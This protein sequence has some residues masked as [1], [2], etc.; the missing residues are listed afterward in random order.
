M[1]NS[2]VQKTLTGFFSVR[3][4]YLEA[5]LEQKNKNKE[6]VWSSITTHEGSVQHLDFLTDYEKE[7]FKTA[8]EIDQLYVIE[9]A[10]DRVGHICQSQSVNVFL[11]A[12]VH[13]KYLHKIHM[14]AWRKG[15][16]SLYYCRSK[17][18]QRADKVSQKVQCQ[19][20]DNV[21]KGSLNGLGECLA[22]Q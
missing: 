6:S 1:A 11:P 17:S 14:L 5:C 3:N 22:C 4:K 13:K 8:Y 10:A 15:V 9:Y 18:L 21:L 20:L 2:F 16:K 12:D 19:V 7:V